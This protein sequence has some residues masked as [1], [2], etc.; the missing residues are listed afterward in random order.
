M[1]SS[2]VI[3]SIKPVIGFSILSYLPYRFENDQVMHLLGIT[4]S[5]ISLTGLAWG[6]SIS[7]SSLSAQAYVMIGTAIFSTDFCIRTLNSTSLMLHGCIGL[8]NI[9]SDFACQHLSAIN[10]V[11]KEKPQNLHRSSAAGV[12]LPHAQQLT[13]LV[14]FFLL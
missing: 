4:L 12:L 14:S 10:Y 2:L 13:I 8:M 1:F 6:S 11:F 5:E 9:E 7:F 3:S